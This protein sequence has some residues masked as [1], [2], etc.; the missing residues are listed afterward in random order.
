MLKKKRTIKPS[1]QEP[2]KEKNSKQSLHCL[3]QLRTE[4]EGTNLK[5]QGIGNKNSL[6]KESMIKIR[7]LYDMLQNFKLENEKLWVD[8]MTEKLKYLISEGLEEHYVPYKSEILSQ[9]DT[10]ACSAQVTSLN[11]TETLKEVSPG[12]KLEDWELSTED[13][14]NIITDPSELNQYNYYDSHDFTQS[15]GEHTSSLEEYLY[16][17]HM[18]HLYITPSNIQG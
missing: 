13:I 8:T 17:S 11:I 16:S 5:I 12:K 10:A 9:K 1:I 15:S 6:V 3:N 18:D 2:N 14:R 7:F 4:L